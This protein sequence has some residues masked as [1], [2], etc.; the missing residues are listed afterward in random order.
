MPSDRLS[1]ILKLPKIFSVFYTA[2]FPNL[3]DTLT[4]LSAL[5]N[6]GVDLIELGMPFSD[7]IAD[8]PTIQASS[9]R[10][11]SNG[12]TLSQILDSVISF[13][14]R[15]QTPI[16]LMG[17]IN[18]VYQY[19]VG[20][21]ADDSLSAGVDGVIL[22]DLP[23]EE[24][25]RSYSEILVKDR[26]PIVPI[27]SPTTSNE[28]IREYADISPGL[29]YLVS[30]F[31]VTGGSFVLSTREF[32]Y[33]ERVSC[34]APNVTRLVGFG[35]SEREQVQAVFSV[36]EGVVIGSAF[37]RQ[38]EAHGANIEMIEKFVKER[39]PLTNRH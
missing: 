7:P 1:N 26:L 24:F 8:G 21:F 3:N 4:V 25:K 29:L 17:S 28:R 14:L 6:S 23:L 30:S 38:L 31:G 16:L 27:V 35:I 10:A 32:E 34:C 39:N 9:N 33:M 5:A 22:P 36:A 15:H 12:V 2:G 13:R 11:I 37:I 20:R 18:T 19:G